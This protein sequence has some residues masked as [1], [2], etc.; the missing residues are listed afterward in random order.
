MTRLLAANP[1]TAATTRPRVYTTA[2]REFLPQE[3]DEVA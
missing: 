3:F 1:T 2:M